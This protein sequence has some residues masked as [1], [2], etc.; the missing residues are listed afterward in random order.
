M[1]YH[2]WFDGEFKVVNGP[3]KDE[4]RAYLV[5]FNETR[6]MARDAG[7][8]ATLPDPVRDATDLHIG[9]P[10]AAYFVG[11]KGSYGHDRDPSILDY[12][13]PPG[14]SLSDWVIPTVDEEGFV[15]V[16]MY[17]WDQGKA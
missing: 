15:T 17:P 3:L 1:G 8:A 4:H 2:T 11:G 13:E 10:D 12:N 6:R 7:I 16:R 14:A 9:S 5:A